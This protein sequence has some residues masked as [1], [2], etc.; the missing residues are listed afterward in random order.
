MCVYIY[1][2]IYRSRWLTSGAKHLR[3]NSIRVTSEHRNSSP[4]IAIPPICTQAIL[5]R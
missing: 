3:F 2:Y 1:I 4:F 5:R